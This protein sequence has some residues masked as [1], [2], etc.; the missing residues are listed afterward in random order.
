MVVSDSASNEVMAADIG[1]GRRLPQLA[2]G[3]DLPLEHPARG[4]TGS[5]SRDGNPVS[6]V[7]SSLACLTPNLMIVGRDLAQGFRRSSLTMCAQ[8]CNIH[9]DTHDPVRLHTVAQDIFK[10]W[11]QPHCKDVETTR[12]QGNH[13]KNL[14]ASKQ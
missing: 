5:P 10:E 7:R 4:V 1:R 11:F 3:G 6:D 14:K 13:V 9:A 8:T 2:G 12:G